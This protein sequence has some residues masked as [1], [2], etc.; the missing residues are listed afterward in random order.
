MKKYNVNFPQSIWEAAKTKAG[1]TPLSAIIRRLVEMWL[2][3][4]ID[5]T[6]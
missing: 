3:G 2:D 5:I 1:L 4:K 6:K